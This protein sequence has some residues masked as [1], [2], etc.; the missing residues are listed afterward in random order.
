MAKR[1]T[2]SEKWNRPWFRQ[3]PPAYKALWILM[4]DKCDIAGIWYVDFELAS[5]MIGEKISPD[6]AKSLFGKQIKVL[7]CGSRWLINGFT[8]F[9][10]GKLKPNNNLHNAVLAK[11]EL[12]NSG[13]NVG[14]N[15]PSEGDKDKDKEK[16]KVIVSAVNDN[17]TGIMPQLFKEPTIAE[18]ISKAKDLHFEMSESEALDFIRFNRSREWRVSGTPMIEW[19]PFLLKFLQKRD[20][21]ILSDK[22]EK[23]RPPTDVKDYY[24]KQFNPNGKA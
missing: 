15:S 18:I 10:Y 11:L 9:Q 16:D 2:D 24:G 6:K 5:F 23:E 7:D 20:E 19:P 1:F 22:I 17:T 13:A 4:L 12:I 21:R 3:L 8:E 14:L